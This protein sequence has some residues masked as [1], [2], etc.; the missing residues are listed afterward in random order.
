M[1]ACAELSPCSADAMITYTCHRCHSTKLQKNGRTKTGQQKFQCKACGFYGTLATKDAECPQRMPNARSGII[2]LN[3]CSSNT[4]RSGQLP[5]SSR[6]VA[7][8]F[9]VFSKK[10]LTA[11]GETIQPLTERP[12]LEIDERWSFVGRKSNLVWVWIALERQTRRICRFRYWRSRR[13]NL[14]QRVGLLACELSHACDRL[15]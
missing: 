3:S 4:A 9:V 7:P 6:S 12:I 1:V 15:H 10:V 8:P 11:S 2:W 14:S 5:V 13:S